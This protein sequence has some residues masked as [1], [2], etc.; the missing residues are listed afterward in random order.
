[1]L[2]SS[3]VSR[4]ISR[5]IF[6]LPLNETEDEDLVEVG[7]QMHMSTVE[8]MIKDNEESIEH[9]RLGMRVKIGHETRVLRRAEQ[10]FERKKNHP[11]LVRSILPLK[12]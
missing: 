3:P 4:F 10:T 11:I 8:T 9:E 7:K 1:M 2:A 6:D 5:H 12:H